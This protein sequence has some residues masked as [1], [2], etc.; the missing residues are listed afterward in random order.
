MGQ[1]FGR[2]EKRRRQTT[3]D[4]FEQRLRQAGLIDELFEQFATFL[5]QAGYE[6]KG[7]QIIDATLIPVPTQRNSRE[8]NQQI[9]QG[10]IP[11]DWLEQPHKL[12]QK[13]T[14]ARWTKKHGQSYFGF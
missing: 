11:A 2:I 12:A 6:A 7:G 9:K 10:A 8:E 1:G 14:D 13:D 5:R 3:L 4:G